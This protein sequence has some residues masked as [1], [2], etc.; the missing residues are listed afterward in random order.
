MIASLRGTV[1]ALK[2]DQAVIEVGGVGLAI[3][4]TPDTI[5][6][7]R[8]GEEAAIATHLVVRE[9]A[10]TLYGFASEDER[11]TFVTLQTVSGVGP[12]LALAMVAVHNPDTLRRAVA[13]EDLATLTT[14]PGIGKKSAQRIILE[15]GDKLGPPVTAGAAELDPAIGAAEVGES[16]ASNAL[17]T[18]VVDALIGLGWNA[19]AAEKA[20]S[21][22]VASAEFAGE[23]QL[24]IGAVLRAALQQLG[25]KRVG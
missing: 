24:D 5:S 21:D 19:K 22:V 4:A 20:V 9:D 11:D 14:V 3:S 1:L 18:E 10:L 2:L 25:G 6:R 23:D 16:A 13:Q 12:R 8:V 7:L 17:P 15:L